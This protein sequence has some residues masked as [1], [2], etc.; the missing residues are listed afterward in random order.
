MSR[1]P[2]PLTVAALALAASV[3]AT[4]Y[5]HRE[6]QGA[7]QR[8]LDERL[9][10]AG[11]SA[12]ALLPPTGWSPEALRALMRSNSLD[13]AFILDE[14]LLVQASATGP[15]GRRVDLLRV[16][17][18][19]VER[20]FAGEANV[21][22]GYDV[23]GLSVGGGYFPLRGPDGRVAAVLAL[24][25]GTAF[26]EATRAISRARTVSLVF[27]RRWA[28]RSSRPSGR[29]VSDSGASLVS[30]RRAPRP[31]PASR[32]PRPTRFATRSA[33]SA[34]RSSSSASAPAPP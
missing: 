24:E 2:F 12:T 7:V 26:T 33:S 30:G 17:R 6:A 5:L 8:E 11:N 13:G 22:V 4:L 21:G 16:D 34:A 32:R 10:A 9:L 18:R 3:V 31:S 28:W 20:A 1:A 15:A 25:A 27:S 14:A 19:R 29:A 23:G